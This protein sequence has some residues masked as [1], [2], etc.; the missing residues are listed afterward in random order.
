MASNILRSTRRVL[1]GMVL[2]ATAVGGWIWYSSLS[3]PA[4]PSVAQRLADSG[5]GQ[6]GAGD[7][8]LVTHRGQVIDD[9]IF[10]GKPSLVFFGFTHCPDVCPTTLGDMQYWLSRLGEDADKI[11][12]FFVTTD[13][14]RDTVDVMAEY[15][16]WFSDDITG[17][18]GNA[19]EMAEMVS[20][21]GV[22]TR[23]VPIDGGGYNVDHTASVF[24]LDRDGRFFGTIAYEEDREIAFT[25]VRRLADEG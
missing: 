10:L 24:M 2:L 18:T 22:Y 6:Y 21:W 1:W 12:V 8:Q 9:S 17:L 4:R 3:A 20:A 15:V 7:Y 5:D 11:Q 16:S 14:E 25:K 19:D 13:P 23:K